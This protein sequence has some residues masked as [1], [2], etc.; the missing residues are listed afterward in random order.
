[1]TGTPSLQQGGTWENEKN[2]KWGE[3]GKFWFVKEGAEG[4]SVISWGG[5]RWVLGPFLVGSV[6]P[7]PAMTRFCYPLKSRAQ[8]YCIF[9]VG[10]KL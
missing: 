1:M 8:H 6:L 7:L 10:S 2:C 3:P 9:K 4:V 5:G